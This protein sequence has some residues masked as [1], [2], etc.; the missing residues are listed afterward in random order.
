VTGSRRF[1][2]CLP[3]LA[4]LAAGCAHR[5]AERREPLR[6]V[7][8]LLF[9]VP[10]IG[11]VSGFA[12]HE[13]EGEPRLVVSG[14]GGAQVRSPSGRLLRS[15]A[16]AG[17]EDVPWHVE[18]RDIDADG[19]PEFLNRGG[20]WH[21]TGI[22]DSDGELAWSHRPE[23]APNSMAAGHLD[24]DGRIDFVVGM[25]GGGGVE[26]LDAAGSPVW[27]QPDAN[28]WRVELL[29]ADGDGDQEILHTNVDG[30]FT[31]RDG[32]G[33]VLRRFETGHYATEFAVLPGPR[34]LQHAGDRF[35]VLDADGQ[36][37]RE[38]PTPVGGEMF[39]DMQARELRLAGASERLIAVLESRRVSDLSV[40]HVFDERGERVHEELLEEACAGLGS[41]PAGS[42]EEILVGCAGRVWR[43]RLAGTPGPA[44]EPTLSAA[45]LLEPGD[46]LG[47]LCFGDPPELVRRRLALLPG[48]M[49][50]DSA[51]SR[52]EVQR[53]GASLVLAPEFE[54]G[55][56]SEILVVARP[57]SPP[58]D[59]ST[60]RSA[61]EAL[62][63]WAEES[64]G[65][66][67]ES[68]GLPT[69]AE[70]NETVTTHRWERAGSDAVLGIRIREGNPGSWR[71]VV[72]LLAKP[73]RPAPDAPLPAAPSP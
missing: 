18:P 2:I 17:T 73:H 13:L 19:R 55:G 57:G 63:G 27:A 35:L 29:D 47:P 34:I 50:A 51:C 49:C 38:L 9:E 56:L 59:E 14:N 53:G 67:A 61:W 4:A 58:D 62:A 33:R 65:A 39:G 43:Y 32:D 70:L 22:F 12:W 21:P 3:I 20:N 10:E 26:R 6:L 41:W 45:A 52:Y 1:W 40:L 66:A 42:G 60:V 37:Q 48:A 28:V 30:R 5:A 24:A 68:R 7:K 8:E 11:T 16:F 72:M 44:G 69:L 31:L 54:D 23:S 15:L 25:N 46:A 71:H 64:Y 36:V